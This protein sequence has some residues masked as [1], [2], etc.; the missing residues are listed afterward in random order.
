MVSF[1]GV[2][3]Q[4]GFT[5]RADNKGDRE[6][7]VAY[8]VVNHDGTDFY[9]LTAVG[10][11]TVNTGLVLTDDDYAWSWPTADGTTPVDVVEV[12][13]CK[14]GYYGTGGAACFAW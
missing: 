9:A 10:T 12:A 6:V 13:Q 8:T 5:N 2:T 1:E 4:V 3:G 11:W 14:A 7:G